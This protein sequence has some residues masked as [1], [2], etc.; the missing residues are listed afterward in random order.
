[1]CKQFLAVPLWLS[2]TPEESTHM[3]PT[4][5]CHGFI[6]LHFAERPFCCFCVVNAHFLPIS[7]TVMH[8][9]IKQDLQGTVSHHLYSM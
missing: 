8:L 7:F 9:Y 2:F 3:N 1:M 6:K 4:Q 5:H